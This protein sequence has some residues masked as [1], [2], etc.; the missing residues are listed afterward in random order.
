MEKESNKTIFNK[1][2][3]IKKINNLDFNLHQH[4]LYELVCISKGELKLTID[5]QVYNLKPN[6]IYIIKPGQVHQWI[7]D[8]SSDDCKGIIFHFSKDFLPSYNMVNQLYEESSFPIVELPKHTFDNISLLILMLEEEQNNSLN[9]YLFGSIL[10]YVLK[11]KK[12]SENLYYKD[13]RIYLLLDLIE[14]NFINEKSAAFY[15]RELDLTTKRLNELTKKYL[16]KT[17]SS[18][19]FERNIIEIKRELTYSNL[20]IAKISDKLGFNTS[21]HFSKFFKQNTSYSPLEFREQ[22]KLMYK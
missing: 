22:K 15:A 7:Q 17:V 3:N 9:A 18:L 12:S 11:F 21:S 2:F 19:I 14:K 10:E 8:R 1:S 20:T 13:E 5:F 4:S 16:N 6:T